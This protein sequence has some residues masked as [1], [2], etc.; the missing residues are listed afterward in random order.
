M[1]K[2]V[3]LL[4]ICLLTGCSKVAENKTPDFVFTKGIQSSEEY[5]NLID[6]VRNS[7]EYTSVLI[8]ENE[9]THIFT[10]ENE[11]FKAMLTFTPVDEVAIKKYYSQFPDSKDMKEALEQTLSMQPNLQQD[12]YLTFKGDLR[13]AFFNF[14]TNEFSI[15]DLRCTLQSGSYGG[16]ISNPSIQH[17]ITSLDGKAP[18]SSP[19]FIRKDD[20]TLLQAPSLKVESSIPE[21]NFE[22]QLLQQ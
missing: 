17:L 13:E 21:F 22:L 19:F 10:G 14:K 15:V 9:P 2:I 7:E 18:L 20:P 1:K 6:Q 16:T 3:L 8:N 5:K 12:L 11:L 4:A